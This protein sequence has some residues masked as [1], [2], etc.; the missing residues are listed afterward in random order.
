VLGFEQFH[1]GGGTWKRGVPEERASADEVL[2]PTSWNHLEA[3]VLFSLG[4]P[5][6]VFAQEGV[7]GGVFDPGVTD[8]FVHPMP[9]PDMK[10]ASKR[11]LQAVFQKWQASV[12]THYYR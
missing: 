6:L 3:G 11:G 5:L 10:T 7:T 9:S 8:V 2:I 4:L 1:S 12:R